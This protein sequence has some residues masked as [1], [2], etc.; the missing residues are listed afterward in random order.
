MLTRQVFAVSLIF[1]LLGSS[2]FAA[3]GWQA[4]AA[5]V[6]ITPEKP[7]WMSGYAGRNKPA[8]GK[9]TELWAKA[10]VLAD[11]NGKSA[12][13]VT[14][15]LIGIDRATSLAVREQI[16]KECGFDRDEIALATSHTHCGPVVGRNLGSM[17]F[18]DDEQ[19]Q[20]VRTYTE[21]LQTKIVQVVQ[22]A[23]QNRE[24]VSLA[25]E[26]GRSTFAVN[27]RNNRQ[28][29]VP[30]LRE[31]GELRGP[32]DHDVPVLAVRTEGGK[33]KAIVFGYACHATTLSFYQWCG[34]WPGFAQAQLEERFPGA[35]AL[36]WAG[37][38]A[39]QNPL[40]RRS[41]DLARSYGQRLA[42]TVER[43][44]GGVMQPVAPK[45]ATSYGAIKLGFASLPN[46][47]QLE[48]DRESKNRY[49]A[50]RARLLLAQWEQHGGLS[51]SYPYPVQVW[52]LG[53]EVTFVLL[54]GEVVVDFAL[55][56]KRELAGTGTWVAGY[57][58][59]VMAYIPSLRVLR[60][61][62]YEGGGAMVYYGL[63]SPWNAQVEEQI[64]AEVHR[65][66]KALKN[67]AK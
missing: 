20:L 13:L 40:P 63:P 51:E 44:V 41:V 12:V 64:I 45:L 5:K 35:V 37:C 62:G 28:G 61:G 2:A 30:Q 15:D 53:D 34:D 58:N 46:R 39:D 52:K 36:F 32:V 56:L 67:A 7:M 8:E 60:E 3:D 33:L 65:Q 47:E 9:L 43:E 22:A 19:K 23:Q 24:D 18:L 1:S 66:I 16:E 25:W 59:D 42:A 54:G 27:R 31:R 10:I 57:S 21:Q 4:G 49:V 48:Q 29:D 26:S 38:G 50:S 55:R 6:K 11:A 14:L 17:Y